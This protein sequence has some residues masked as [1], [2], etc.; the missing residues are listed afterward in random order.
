MKVLVGAQDRD[1]DSSHTLVTHPIIATSHW[2]ILVL[3]VLCFEKRGWFSQ[4]T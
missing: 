3:A 1:E 2:S 4:D